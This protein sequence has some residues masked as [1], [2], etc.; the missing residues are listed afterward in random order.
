LSMMGSQ[1]GGSGEGSKEDRVKAMYEGNL[2]FNMLLRSLETC[3]KPVAAAING[4]ALGGGLEVT[5][6]CHYRVASDNPKT[7]IGLPEAKV[8]LLPGGGGTQRLPRLIGAQAA[9]P[10]ILQ[11]T[12]LSPEKALKAGILHKVVPA[13]ELVSAAKAWLKEGLAQ[14]KIKLGKKGPEVYPIAVQPWDMPGYKVPGG[15]PNGKGGSQVF[16]IGNATLHKQTHG[17]FPA[18]RYIMS[19]VYEGLQVPMEAGIRIET[20]YFTKLLMD[21]RSKAMIRSLFLSMQELAKGA[22]RPSDVAPFQV[23]KLGILGAGMMGAG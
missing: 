9:L 3:G 22:R 11:G 16:T 21:P 19:C 4:T 23:K 6:A 7:Q 10:L 5:L 2:K 17:N 12:S 20:R 15:D 14:D 13:A 8:G 18:Q 1:A